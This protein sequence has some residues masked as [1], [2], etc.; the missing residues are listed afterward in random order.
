MKAMKK[1]RIK[2]LQTVKIPFKTKFFGQFNK[3]DQFPGFSTSKTLVR[4]PIKESIDD[5]IDYMK[6]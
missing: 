1:Y 4:G 6:I 3:F 5:L 2:I